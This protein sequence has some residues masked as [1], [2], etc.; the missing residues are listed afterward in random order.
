VGKPK[1]KPTV[2]NMVHVSYLRIYASLRNETF[3]SLMELNQ[4]ILILLN[5]H[6]RTPFQKRPYSRF[7]R[8]VQDELPLLSALPADTFV[9]KHTALAK[10]Q[11]NYHVILGEDYHQYS[12]PYQHI[13]KKVKLVYDSDVVEVFMGLQRI[14][15][16]TRNYKKYDYTTLAEHMPEPHQSYLEAKG[17]DADYFLNKAK[18]TGANAVEITRRILESRSFMQ[19]SYNACLGLIRLMEHYGEERFENASKRA[20]PASRVNYGTIS[21][22]L[23][24]GLDKQPDDPLTEPTDLFTHENIRGPQAFK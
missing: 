22:I 8:F 19:Q 21:N 13:G 6:N 23:K 11:K 7:D 4:R 10:V 12:V 14:A 5:K 3:Y 1:D 2:E 18:A 16:H 20:V 15:I 24:K 9:I 17:W